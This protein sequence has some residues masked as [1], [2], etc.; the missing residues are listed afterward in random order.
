MRASS[1]CTRNGETEMTAQA[2][3]LKSAVLAEL[4]PTV[5]WATP[6]GYPDS[7]ALCLIDSI[8]SIGQKYGGVRSV[9]RRY[10][11]FR[12][13]QGGD[14]E[15]DGAVE[16]AATFDELGSVDSWASKIGTHNRVYSRGEAPLK[17]A[18]TPWL[19]RFVSHSRLPPPSGG[20]RAD[21]GGVNRGA[22][23]Q[24][25]GGEGLPPV[26]VF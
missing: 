17:A 15:R 4:G 12:A 3:I 11:D 24:F 26:L 6:D 23:G 7:L 8:Q 10:R 25:D 18:V 1:R 13:S 19:F 20:L 14:A 9:V 5:E 16:L 2:E 22:A 21:G